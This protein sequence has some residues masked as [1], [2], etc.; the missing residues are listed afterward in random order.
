MDNRNAKGGPTAYLCRKNTSERELRNMADTKD[1]SYIPPGGLTTIPELGEFVPRRGGRIFVAFARFITHLFGWKV[2]GSLPNSQKLMVIGAP[3]SSNWD[4][5]L[6]IMAG[7]YL[8]VRISWMAKHTLFRGPFGYIMRWL[9][10][11]PVDRRASQGTVGQAIERFQKQEGL[12]LCITPEGTRR[13]VREWKQGFYHI[14]MGADVPIVAAA[15][16]YGRKRVHFGPVFKPSGN[17][18][19]DLPIIKSYYEGVKARNPENWS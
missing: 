10:G 4:W 12:I 19:E 6:T 13:K 9:G 11:V 17:L 2:E 8:G 14:A 18:E 15:F 1:L 3:H 7:S 5:V 16:D